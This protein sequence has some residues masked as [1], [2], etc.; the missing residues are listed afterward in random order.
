MCEFTGSRSRS[1]AV[2]GRCTNTSGYLAQA[3]INELIMRNGI[4]AFYDAQSNS[5]VMIYNGLYYHVDER[6]TLRG[7][8]TEHR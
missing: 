2:P 8:F 1:D 4:R 7:T 5:N 6:E 3:E